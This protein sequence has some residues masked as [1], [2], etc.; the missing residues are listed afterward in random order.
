MAKKSLKSGKSIMV[1]IDALNIAKYNPRVDLKPDDPEYQEIKS[2][3]EEFG[4]TDFIVVNKDLTVIGGHQRLKVLKDLGYDEIEVSQVDL[5]KTQ[6][7]QLNLALNNIK[8]RWDSDKLTELLLD[9]KSINANLDLTGFST[10]EVDKLISGSV[11]KPE[12]NVFAEVE[13]MGLGGSNKD[14]DTIPEDSPEYDESC[15]DGV[16]M[17]TCPHCGEQFP[18]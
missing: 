15:A 11:F 13:D 2:S 14:Y 8:G 7:K 6:E 5:T 16:E 10:Y 9:L 17:I 18:K 4:Y 12:R 3:I 1:C